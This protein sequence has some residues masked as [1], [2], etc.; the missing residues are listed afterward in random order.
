DDES[1]GFNTAPI[2]V[3]ERTARKFSSAG[4]GVGNDPADLFSALQ[5]GDF[6][7]PG[8]AADSKSY[9]RVTLETHPYASHEAIVDSVEALGFRAYSFAEQF[10]EIRRFFV[11]FYLGMSVVGL[12]ALATASLGIINT[13]VMSITERR[14]EIGILKSLGADEREI[15]LA[16]LTESAVIGAIGAAIGI[17]LGWLGTRIAAF[18][19]RLIME[20]EEMVVY[21][22]FA[23]PY[24]LILLAFSFGVVVALLAGLY[25]AARAARVDPV[26]ALRSE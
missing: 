20:R 2:V 16:F 14:R 12:I 24:W 21:D 25:P 4:L 7:A 23:L 6:F 10:K 26:E 15:R 8:G 19:M 11:Y 5:S 17:F 9:P 22:P 13:M 1:Y 3:T 18:V